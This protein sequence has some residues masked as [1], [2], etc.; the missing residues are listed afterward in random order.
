MVGGDRCKTGEV[1]FRPWETVSFIFN[2]FQFRIL[3]TRVF[4]TLEVK[5][6]TKLRVE[7]YVITHGLLPFIIRNKGTI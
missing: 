2:P 7:K 4:V 6:Y 5:D 1:G 3:E